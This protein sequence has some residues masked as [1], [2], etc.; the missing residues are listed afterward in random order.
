VGTAQEKNKETIRTFLISGIA[1]KASDYKAVI[2]ACVA[3]DIKVHFPAPTSLKGEGSEGGDG[4]LRGLDLL[5]DMVADSHDGGIYLSGTTRI[6]ILHMIAEGDFVAVRFMLRATT[7]LR[8]EQ[9]ENHYHH[10][11][12]LRDGKID[13]IWEYVDTLYSSRMLWEVLEKKKRTA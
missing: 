13:E 10:L 9:Y 6:E 4:T 7:T 2:G 8:H 1:G 5:V 12:H 11:F 3:P